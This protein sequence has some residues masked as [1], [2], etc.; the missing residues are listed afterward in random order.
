MTLRLRVPNLTSFL[1]PGLLLA[2]GVALGGLALVLLAFVAFLV[3][4]DRVLDR[5]IGFAGWSM[6][7]AE[8]TYRRLSRQRRR[9]EIAGRLRRRPAEHLA[10]LALDTGWPAVAQRRHF[11]LQAIEVESIVG[12]VDGPKA[13]AFDRAFR[14]PKWSRGRWTQMCLAARRGT[15]MPP[16]AVYRVAGEHYVSD[17]HHRVSVARALGAHTIDAEI[18][19]LEQPARRDRPWGHG[20]VQHLPQPDRRATTG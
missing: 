19:E 2:A 17:G 4:V 1:L 10:Y 20:H 14:P 13:L 3:A 12:T 16:I 18:V 7:E 8:H 15:A 11:G 5:V 9:S 6:V